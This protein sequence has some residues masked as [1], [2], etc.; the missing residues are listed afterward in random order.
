[1]N[2]LFLV[3]RYY[4]ERKMARSRFY[5]MEAVGRCDGVH[6]TYWG[7]GFSG[8]CH[9]DT[10]A[11]NIK[12]V[13]GMSTFD[14]IHVYKPEDHKHVAGCLTP[15][16]IDYDEARH[17]K[18]KIREV[19]RNGIGL[20]VFHYHNEMQALMKY[21]R[22]TRGCRLVHLPH[23]AERSIFEPVARP[24]EERSIPLLLT[25]AL[26]Q[27][28][29]PLRA[30]YAALIRAG[31]LPGEI[32]PHPG[33]RLPGIDHIGDQYVDYANHLGRARLTLV[34]SSKFHYALAKYFEASMAGCLL[35]GDVP[36]ELHDTLGRYMVRL[37]P[38]MSDDQIIDRVTWWMEHDAEAQAMAVESQQLALSHFT[39]E[40]YAEQFV[41]VARD[42][43]DTEQRR[44]R[45]QQTRHRLADAPRLVQTWFGRGVSGMLR[46]DNVYR[47]AQVADP[48]D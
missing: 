21:S 22:L 41:R 46:N 47:R 25:G 45:V 35:I 4:Y 16:S 14:L 29:Y 6:L 19:L 3:S 13:F 27:K 20:A 37:T 12:R 38:D 10:L 11:D 24:W 32:R 31:R 2:I 44:Q 5:Q 42:F 28:H 8:Y 34:S 33:Y 18:A 23:C 36:Q 15:K 40:R 9:T 30:R 39:M 43:L 7:T 1:M 17:R 26:G 48:L